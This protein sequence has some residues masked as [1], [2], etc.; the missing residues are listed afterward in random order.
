ME[1]ENNPSSHIK[2]GSRIRVTIVRESEPSPPQSPPAPDLPQLGRCRLPT[3]PVQTQEATPSAGRDRASQ[4]S[5]LPT[6]DAHQICVARVDGWKADGW[7]AGWTVLFGLVKIQ[8]PKSGPGFSWG[9][10][11]QAEEHP[12]R[13]NFH[14]FQGSFGQ[15]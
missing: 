9:S 6:A 4:P 13:K 8:P 2:Y 5:M 15:I 11:W 7:L 14:S 3:A 10:L 1:I 12:F